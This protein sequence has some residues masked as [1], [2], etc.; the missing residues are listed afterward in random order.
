MARPPG[1]DRATVLEAV[2]HQFRKTGYAGTSL[3]DITAA[4]G[5]GRGSL[6]AAFGDKHC[7]FMEAL[8]EYCDQSEAMIRAMLDGPDREALSRL[9]ANLI[10]AAEAPFADDELLGCMAGK[11]AVELATQ[12][13][14]VAERVSSGLRAM[15]AGLAGCIAAAQRHGDVEPDADASATAAMMLAVVRGMDVMARAGYL[16]DDLVALAQQ[17]FLGLP[18]SR[19]GRRSAITFS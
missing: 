6:Y 9:H 14:E 19:K 13:P 1:F 17:A 12:D 16:R 5:L 11:F 15:Q 18:L 3:D 2:Q 4:T 10:F 8:G 7:L